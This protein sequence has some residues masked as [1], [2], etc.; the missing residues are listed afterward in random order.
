MAAVRD[1]LIGKLGRFEWRAAARLEL[2][3]PIRTGYEWYT[4][5]KIKHRVLPMTNPAAM[6]L[7]VPMLVG[8]FGV[9]SALSIVVEE[10]SPSQSCVLYRSA[11]FSRH[12]FHALGPRSTKLTRCSLLGHRM[13]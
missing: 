8:N 4:N 12:T 9:L 3:Q 11:T 6:L 5:T 1:P 13:H 10:R 2:N 7:P